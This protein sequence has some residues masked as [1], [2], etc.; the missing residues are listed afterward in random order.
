VPV[1]RRQCGIACYRSLGLGASLQH[2][3]VERVAMLPSEYL[4]EKLTPHPLPTK[5]GGVLRTI[6]DARAYMQA[7]SKTRKSRAHWKRASLLLLEEV[8]AAA[9]TR[10]VQVALFMDGKLDPTFERVSNARRWR[11]AYK[12]EED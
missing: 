1:G 4:S 12:Q 10:Q 8:G 2:Q 7:L 11:D 3:G 6:G 9:L 5:D